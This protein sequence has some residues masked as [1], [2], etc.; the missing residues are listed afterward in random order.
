MYLL[1]CL[2]CIIHF[3]SAGGVRLVESM[4]IDRQ[5]DK[6]EENTRRRKRKRMK[7]RHDTTELRTV[8]QLQIKRQENRKNNVLICCEKLL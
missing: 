7:T 5:G 3:G 2:T 8:Y 6:T 4:Q 1:G